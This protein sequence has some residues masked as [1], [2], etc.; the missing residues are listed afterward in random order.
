M[1]RKT[2][3]AVPPPRCGRGPTE[4]RL[5]RVIRSRCLRAA[6]LF[7]LCMLVAKCGRPSDGILSAVHYLDFVEAEGELLCVVVSDRRLP[8]PLSDQFGEGA[9]AAHTRQIR[10]LDEEFQLDEGRLFCVAAREEPP[11][12]DQMKIPPLTLDGDSSAQRAKI[13]ALEEVLE[14]MGL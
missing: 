13:L 9:T 2:E 5:I 12:I 14:C 7:V 4:T 3:S 10:L 11:R 1:A 8:S 6:G